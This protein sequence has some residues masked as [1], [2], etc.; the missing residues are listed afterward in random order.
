MRVLSKC[1][2]VMN[3]VQ[4]KLFR[5]FSKNFEV[6]S[7]ADSLLHATTIGI[8]EDDHRGASKVKLSK[9]GI[10]Y[11]LVE[12]FCKEAEQGSSSPVAEVQVVRCM[13]ML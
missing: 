9:G 3:V 8:A 6:V 5:V 2:K 13:S 11:G 7:T 10:P 12:A 1:K 4:D